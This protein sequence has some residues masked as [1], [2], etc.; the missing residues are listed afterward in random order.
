MEINKFN[1]IDVLSGLKLLDD[2]SADIIIID[3]PYNIGK[4]FGN[5]K[6]NMN[7][8]DGRIKKNT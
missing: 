1:L 8:E 7:L 6:D 2:E 4:D 3:P 5:N